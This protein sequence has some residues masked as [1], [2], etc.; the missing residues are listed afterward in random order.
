MHVS[1]L[2]SEIA[3]QLRDLPV[4]HTQL[5]VAVLLQ[6]WLNQRLKAF[7]LPLDEC[8]RYLLSLDLSEFPTEM[9]ILERR[10]VEYFVARMQRKRQ[11]LLDGILRLIWRSVAV[12]SEESCPYHQYSLKFL[13]NEVD[14]KLVLY[15]DFCGWHQ[16]S[17]DVK[18]LIP[19]RE[20]LKRLG[21]LLQV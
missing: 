3:R 14:D 19:D 18:L 6:N 10:D 21:P 16:E 4:E 9:S 13:Y 8:G 17:A 11:E 2:Y 1:R 15:C 12:E 20:V 7:M 5:D